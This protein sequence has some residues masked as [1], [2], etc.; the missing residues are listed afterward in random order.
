MYLFFLRTYFIDYFE[1]PYIEIV[2]VKTG[3]EIRNYILNKLNEYQI[4]LS[5]CNE[6]L[7]KF[8]N[9]DKINNEF[10]FENYDYDNDIKNI[11]DLDKL[12]SAINNC[13][14]SNTKLS[15]YLP[16][17]YKY[18]T[19]L[20]FKL[21]NKEIVY[22]GGDIHSINFEKIERKFMYDGLHIL[23]FVEDKYIK[24]EYLKK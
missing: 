19:G 12:D 7:P 15:V 13:I 10:I 1:Q 20:V 4:G 11:L 18:G 23:Q 9:I 21:V 3:E 8:V 24:D 17:N 16:D 22:G 2:N 5:N 14:R 6:L